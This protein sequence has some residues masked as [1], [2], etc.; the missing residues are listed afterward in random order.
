MKIFG[1][2]QIRDIDEFTIKN[3]PIES[4]ELMENA[5][6]VFYNWFIDKINYNKSK[7]ITV[8][9]GKGNNGGDGLAVARMLHDG[10]YRVIVYVLEGPGTS[11]L[12]FRSNLYNFQQL[13][14]S[15][16]HTISEDKA[17]ALEV[18]DYIIDAILGSGLDRTVTGFYEKVITQINYSS[19]RVFSIDI[20]SGL[21]A[22]STTG[23]TSIHAHEILSF[24]FPKLAFMFPE[25]Y[26]SVSNWETLPIGLLTSKIDN[27]TTRN[28]YI[29]R[30]LIKGII[31]QR[32]KFDHKGVYGHAGLIVGSIGMMGAA[33]LS[34][35]ATMRSGVGLLSLQIPS[36]G[37]NIM[38]TAVPEAMISHLDNSECISTITLTE[39]IDAYGI[40]PGLGKNEATRVTL[41]KF[42][43][44]CE[45][46][47]V[48][49]ADA[50]N[51]IASRKTMLELIPEGAILTPH[52]KEFER[53]FGSTGN[54][55]DRHRLQKV[56]SD[57][58]KIYIA[59]KGA[60]TC[61][62]SPKGESYFNSTGNNGMATAG[63]GD[64]L[65][66]IITSL[67]AQG[68]AAREASILGVYVHGLAGDLAAAQL[69]PSG[70]IASDV[71]KKLP[72]AFKGLNDE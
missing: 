23:G 66:G 30:S 15:R 7:L 59:L 21:F 6:R 44:T 28:F 54:D 47:I 29:D 63:S 38:Q 56:V 40:G 37:V 64:V 55:F 2:K 50:L 12:D 53:L 67:L 72:L 68:Y 10:G 36:A 69:G 65:T 31:K 34:S 4:I 33:I 43:T 35:L 58:Y 51:L 8:F 26:E 48:L 45:Q 13:D 57:K 70:M 61:I 24:Q 52:I 62:T 71:V 27:T 25:N 11:S 41:E 39:G 19:A 42:L 46:P 20:P 1:A 9:C 49:D 5:S 60:H 18:S 16:L 22:D 17:L 14:Q 3:M 32:Y